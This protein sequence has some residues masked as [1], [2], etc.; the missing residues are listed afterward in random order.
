MKL[1]GIPYE[2]LAANLI[3]QLVNSLEYIHSK[4]IVHRDI[5]CENLVISRDGQLKLIDFGSS[6]DLDYPIP[7][8]NGQASK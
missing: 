4:N 6:V 3:L 5:K 7:T 8:V 2:K 1:T